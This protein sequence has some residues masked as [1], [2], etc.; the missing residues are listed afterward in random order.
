MNY[1]EFTAASRAPI[2][3][4]YLQQCASSSDQAPLGARY[5]KIFTFLHNISYYIPE[6]HSLTAAKKYSLSKGFWNV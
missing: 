3:S 4:K 1:I 5:E 6:R 2:G